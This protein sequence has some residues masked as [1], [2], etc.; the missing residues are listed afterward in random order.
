MRWMTVPIAAIKGFVKDEC[1]LKASAL[2]YY[3]LFSIVP[4]LAVLFGIAHGFGIEDVLNSNLKVVL[5][6]HPEIA[7]RLTEFIDS[8]LRH[9]KGSLI[10]GFGII[11]LIW[12]VILLFSTIETVFNSIWKTN[13]S[14]TFAAML[15]DYPPIILFAPLFF[16]FI[17]S[18]SIYIFNDMARYARI[19]GLEH[20]PGG[21]E[22]LWIQATTFALSWLFFA[23]LYIFIPAAHVRLAHGALAGLIA[24]ILF[25]LLQQSFIAFQVN[26]TSYSALYGSFAALPLFLLWLQFSWWIVLLGAEIARHLQDSVLLSESQADGEKIAAALPAI[27][28]LLLAESWK[29]FETRSP[30]LSPEEF[31]KEFQLSP[32]LSLQLF[33]MLAHAN[34]LVK[35]THERHEV[36]S[37]YQAACPFG[38]ISMYHLIEALTPDLVRKEAVLSGRNP[39]F[40]VQEW[41]AFFDELKKRTF[42]PNNQQPK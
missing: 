26:L 17:S 4:V 39:Q 5:S 34:L 12:S 18:F 9:A 11:L 41:N 24:A 40:F 30:P 15:R 42:L 22:T 27:G 31:S 20:I 19:F 2:T 21:F 36:E 32:S 23:F 25:Y 35:V 8:T 28:S 38:S 33:S 7:A 10:A 13:S 1:F 6:D 29:R 37:R 14:R 3:T 16:A